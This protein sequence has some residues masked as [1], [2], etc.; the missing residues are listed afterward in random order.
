MRKLSLAAMAATLGMGVAAYAV[1]ASAAVMVDGSGTWGAGTP[2]TA[3]SAPAS[4]F[5]F[6]FSL[7]NPTA[8]NPTDQLSNFSYTLQGATVAG[9]APFVTFY[10]ATNGGLFD[11]TFATPAVDLTFQG[12]VIATNPTSGGPVTISTG[13]FAATAGLNFA[14]TPTG[15]GTITVAAAAAPVPEPASWALMLPALIGAG[16]LFRRRATGEA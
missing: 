3:Y 11:L 7:P 1:P 13:T 12:P 9:M 16:F 8:S 14:T 4:T 6:S 5:A 2:T 15:Q 10:D